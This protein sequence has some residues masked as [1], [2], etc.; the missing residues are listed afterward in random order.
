MG[1]IY[2][3][4][5]III[6]LEMIFKIAVLKSVRIDDI[7][8]TLIFSVQIIMVLGLL[9]NVFKKRASKVILIVSTLILTLY[10]MVQTI[11]YKL[12][13]VPFSFMTLGLAGNA[14]DFTSIIKDAILQNCH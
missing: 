8:F 11:F 12:F 6:Y 2:V 14:L 1:V 3:V 4:A 13:S 10:F 9:C 5:F 7:A